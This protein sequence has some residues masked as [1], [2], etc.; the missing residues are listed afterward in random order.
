ML[1][2]GVSLTAFLV[3][4]SADRGERRRI[5]PG[6]DEDPERRRARPRHRTPASPAGSTAGHGS[7]GGAASHG[8]S[9]CT[10]IPSGSRPQRPAMAPRSAPHIASPPRPAVAHVARR[11]PSSIG[12]PTRKSAM[13][14]RPHIAAPSRPSPS[15]ARGGGRRE[16]AAG[17]D[18][19]ARAS[20]ASS[21][22]SSGSRR[23]GAAARELSRQTA[24]RQTRI[25]RLQQRVQQLQSQKPEGLRGATRSSN[26]CCRRRTACFSASNALQQ[27]D[28]ARLQ[29]LGPQPS[30]ERSAAAPRRPH[31]RG[32]FAAHF[33]SS[34]ALQ[35]EPRSTARQNRWAP[36]H[37]WRRGHR[38]AFVAWL[39]PVFWPYAYSDIFEYTFW[40]YA[41]DPGYWAYAYDDFV[42]TVFWGTRQSVFRVRQT[43]PTSARRSSTVA[44]AN[45]QSAEPASA[46][47]IVRHTRTRASPPGR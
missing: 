25:D 7:S 47:A 1:P 15:A 20:S 29:R 23:P 16:R 34:D 33:R 10:G 2:R 30:A 22:S 31:A 27:T 8:A 17:T 26:G 32:R 42:D 19:D 43:I 13:A 18:R 5:R 21:T 24:E 46:A 45:A 35:A 41:Y 38:A 37:A 9:R 28:Q 40:P 44:R 6:S 14:P 12:P 36:R 3:G 39:G 11:G 4:V